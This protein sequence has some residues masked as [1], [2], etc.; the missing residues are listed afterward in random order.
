MISVASS[1]MFDLTESDQVFLTEG[2]GNIKKTIRIFLY[3]QVR[4]FIL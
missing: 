4:N 1:A 3:I 2:E